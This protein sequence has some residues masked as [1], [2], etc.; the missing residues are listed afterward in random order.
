MSFTNYFKNWLN[1]VTFSALQIFFYHC[2]HW[3]DTSAP[4]V[5]F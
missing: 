2:R 5:A 3:T 1:V 4:R